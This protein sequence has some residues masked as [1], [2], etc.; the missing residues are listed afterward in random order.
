[1]SVIRIAG[2]RCGMGD[3]LAA[4]FTTLTLTPNS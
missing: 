1:V 4:G 3:E 2:Q